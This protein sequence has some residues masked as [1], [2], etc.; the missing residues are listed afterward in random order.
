MPH[1]GVKNAEVSDIKSYL[2]RLPVVPFA[3]RPQ[4]RWR[5]C[6]SLQFILSPMFTALVCAVVKIVRMH[7]SKNKTCA[8]N[9]FLRFYLQPCS[10]L[11]KHKMPIIIYRHVATY[12]ERDYSNDCIIVLRK[13]QMIHKA[14]NIFIFSQFEACIRFFS[15]AG[16]FAGAYQGPCGS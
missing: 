5:V 1:T 14:I 7:L 11:K 4:R 3:S 6:L 8:S 16:K 10:A 9:Q 13:S 15:Y 12:C 2:W